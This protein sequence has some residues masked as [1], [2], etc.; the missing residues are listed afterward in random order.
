[1]N[2]IDL[3]ISE[4]LLKPLK[5]GA[6]VTVAWMLSVHWAAAQPQDFGRGGFRGGGGERGGGERGGER[7]GGERGGQRDRGTRGG[8]GGRGGPPSGFDPTF[9]LQRMDKNGNGRLDPDEVDDRAKFMIG[10]FVPGLDVSKSNSFDDIRKKIQAAREG[11]D[12]GQERTGRG[13]RGNRGNSTP[14]AVE[15]E[16][17]VPGFGEEVTLDPVLGFGG[18]GAFFAVTTTDADEAEA[19]RTLARYDKNKNGKIDRDEIS[20]GRW[21]DD[22]TVYDQNGDGGLSKREL[23][24]RYAR[25]RL[26]KEEERNSESRNRD[27]DRERRN[28]REKERE[29]KKENEDEETYRFLTAHERL[30][31]GIPDWFRQKDVDLDGQ[32]EMSE[33]ESNWTDEVVQRFTSIDV[34]N[35]G[36]LSPTEV[37]QAGD[38]ATGNRATEGSATNASAQTNR[39]GSK[40]K[41]IPKKYLDYARSYIKKYDKNGDQVLNKNEI[42][43]MRRPP[44]NADPNGDGKVTVEEYA[45]SVMR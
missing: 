4:I 11:R 27:R 30:P 32:V 25:R 28:I 33:Y 9:I 13:D 8:G 38:G 41:A 29:S 6:F 40:S 34:D 20:Q 24:I 42:A 5:L 22:P 44:K 43:D 1:M 17:L 21:S 31:K 26:A 15:I 12:Q 10:R 45:R 3:H 7:G 18:S 16:P 36:T 39:G 2:R 37:L 35:N 19:V 23:S 14:E